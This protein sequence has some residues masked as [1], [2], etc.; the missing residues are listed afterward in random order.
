MNSEE[1][2]KKNGRDIIDGRKERKRWN[3]PYS[4]A[5][6][7]IH[8]YGVFNLAWEEIFVPR[9]RQRSEYVACGNNERFISHHDDVKKPKRWKIVNIF[10][11]LRIKEEYI[12]KDNLN[13]PCSE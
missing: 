10:R 11:F 8:T 9:L 6:G 12:M 3:Y 2:G 7:I 4:E 13:R 5:E 1:D